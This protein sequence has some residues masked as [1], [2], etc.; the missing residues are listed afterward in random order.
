[1]DAGG[2]GSRTRSPAIPFKTRACNTE[3]FPRRPLPARRPAWRRGALVF[4]E[5]F[6]V[7]EVLPGRDRGTQG[8]SMMTQ[9]RQQLETMSE[10]LRLRRPQ[11]GAR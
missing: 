2:A 11:E 4:P 1:M 7:I 10:G 3:P 9:V 6:D 8:D 5:L